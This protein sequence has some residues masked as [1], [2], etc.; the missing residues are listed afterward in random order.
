MHVRRILV[1]FVCCIGALVPGDSNAQIAGGPVGAESFRVC[2]R[3]GCL[4]PGSLVR[5]GARIPRLRRHEA[6]VVGLTRDT[7]FLSSAGKA[8]GSPIAVPLG[9]IDQLDVSRG[10]RGPAA[11]AAGGAVMGFLI[12][13]VVGATV[14]YYAAGGPD[15][16]WAGFG[17]LVFG[18]PIGGLTGGLV[19]GM[20]GWDP[21]GSE[22]WQRF[23]NPLRVT[24][25]PIVAPSPPAPR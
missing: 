25:A 6:L 7:L 23:R 13:A 8:Q 24:P 5:V 4:G 22:R 11:S 18:A 14:S 16:E 17:A 9:A 2:Q 15:E 19:G 10:H 21:E 20:L 3:D 12:G 1:S